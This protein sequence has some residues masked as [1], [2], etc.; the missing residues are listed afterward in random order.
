MTKTEIKNAISACNHTTPDC[1]RCPYFKQ[2]QFCRNTLNLDI[3]DLITEQEKEIE[4]L[5][6]KTTE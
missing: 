2:V 1:R 4:R 6:N 5:K 3:L